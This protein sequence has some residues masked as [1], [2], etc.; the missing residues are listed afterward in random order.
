MS[1]ANLRVGL[2]E[3][4]EDLAR[5]VPEDAVKDLLRRWR[6]GGSLLLAASE[7]K[8]DLVSVRVL[9]K[10]RELR[11]RGLDDEVVGSILLGINAAREATPRPTVLMTIPNYGGKTTKQTRSFAEVVGGAQRSLVCMTYNFQKSTQYFDELKGLAVK[12][13]FELEIYVDG[14]LAREESKSR[15]NSSSMTL[16]EI[17]WNFPNAHIFASKKDG[18][19]W[20][21]SHA[22]VFIVDGVK[23]FITSANFSKSAENSNVEIGVLIEDVSTAR[24]ILDQLALINQGAVY[25]KYK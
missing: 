15:K 23:A 13:G 8:P 3:V 16:D 18:E 1:S 17:R 22:K 12:D 24:Q 7:L 10:L 5:N 11:E 25:E 9:Q 2:A 14:R 4:S 19:N 21:T 6:G 20:I